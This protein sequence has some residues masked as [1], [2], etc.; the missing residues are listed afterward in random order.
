MNRMLLG[1]A[2]GAALVYFFD[3]ERGEMRRQR[4]SNWASQYV[5]SDT[6]DQARQA[7]QATM[8]QARALTNQVSN[9]VSQLRSGRK[10]ST[11][12]VSTASNSKMASAS[13][14]L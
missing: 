11:T 8:E 4:A 3:V 10:S 2:I 6:M 9:Q 12:G 5:N 14:Q 13:S 1:A 7:G